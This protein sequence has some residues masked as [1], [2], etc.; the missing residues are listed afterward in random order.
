MHK[1]KYLNSV[2]ESNNRDYRS[3]IQKQNF[4]DSVVNTARRKFEQK[5]QLEKK[6]RKE[7][8]SKLEILDDYDIETAYDLLSELQEMTPLTEEIPYSPYSKINQ[9]LRKKKSKFL[10]YGLFTDKKIGDIFGSMEDF[11]KMKSENMT[12]KKAVKMAKKIL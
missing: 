3:N 10:S 4:G 7:T 11:M 8:L 2:N 1:E 6:R 5:Q 12:K 9:I